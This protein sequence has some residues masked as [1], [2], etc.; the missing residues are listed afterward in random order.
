MVTKCVLLCVRESDLLF[1]ISNIIY[2]L[3]LLVVKSKLRHV[4]CLIFYVTLP[5]R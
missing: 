2:D 3:A 1:Q 4:Q 5:I